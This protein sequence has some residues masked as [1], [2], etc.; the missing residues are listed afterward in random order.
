MASSWRRCAG[1]NES[2]AAGFHIPEF[3]MCDVRRIVKRFLLQN[4]MTGESEGGRTAPGLSE[5]PLRSQITEHQGIVWRVVAGKYVRGIAYVAP[6]RIDVG[7][8][9]SPNDIVKLLRQRDRL[10]SSTI[11]AR[12]GWE[13]ESIHADLTTLSPGGRAEASVDYIT[14]NRREEVRD[15]DELRPRELQ[16]EI[17]VGNEDS[18][19]AIDYGL[20]NLAFDLRDITSRSR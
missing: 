8:Y 11:R 16:M 9:Y 4:T 7:E 12:S 10:K 5:L 19:G 2:G 3:S 15:I 18:K 17:V 6:G 13:M 14:G 20:H 1:V